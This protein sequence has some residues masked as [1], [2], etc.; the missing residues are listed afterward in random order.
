MCTPGVLRCE[1]PSGL[2]CHNLY[3]IFCFI[4]TFKIHFDYSKFIWLFQYFRKN[5]PKHPSDSG[6]FQATTWAIIWSKHL[7][8]RH[9]CFLPMGGRCALT[10]AILWKVRVTSV[11]WLSFNF[12]FASAVRWCS[13]YHVCFTRRRSRVRTS[14]EPHLLF[15]RHNIGCI[16]LSG[17]FIVQC[18]ARTQPPHH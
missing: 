11:F 17:D 2:K 4:M 3:V 16:D 12:A 10:N 14:P 7:A 13:G 5:R 9:L 18:P 1:C 8:W 6:R 15:S